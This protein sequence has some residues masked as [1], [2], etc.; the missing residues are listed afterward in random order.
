[1]QLVE[2]EDRARWLTIAR[3]VT[4]QRRRYGGVLA[5]FAVGI[6]V[7]A[8]LGGALAVARG[9]DLKGDATP[10]GLGCRAC[11]RTD[12][13]QRSAPPAGRALLINE[14]DRGVSGFTFTGD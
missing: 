3:T 10:I 13:P 8:E 4:P 11:Q 2:L 14:R 12:C 7:A 5:E 6:G 9:I 1:M